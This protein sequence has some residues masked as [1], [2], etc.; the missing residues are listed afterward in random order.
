MDMDGLLC[1]ETLSPTDAQ[2]LPA[3]RSPAMARPMT[4][5]G[6]LA[7]E[8]DAAAGISQ[9]LL[10]ATTQSNVHVREV[11]QVVKI[12]SRPPPARRKS[13]LRDVD[14]RVTGSGP[15]AHRPL[16]LKCLLFGRKDEWCAPRRVATFDRCNRILRENPPLAVAAVA[17]DRAPSSFSRHER[18]PTKWLAA[19]HNVV[20]PSAVWP[21]PPSSA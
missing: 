11:P 4:R 19:E 21:P 15:L 8:L 3:Q 1:H 7:Q 16:L 17:A 9:L 14:N 10:A 2:P 6:M 20:D 5:V 12:E 13:R 18:K